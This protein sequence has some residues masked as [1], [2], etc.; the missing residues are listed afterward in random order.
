[1]TLS[2]SLTQWS[3]AKHKEAMRER[4]APL[5]T[6]L[7]DK[8]DKQDEKSQQWDDID[9]PILWWP[10]GKSGKSHWLH[11]H[12][13][14]AHLSVK[15]TQL[16][17]WKWKGQKAKGVHLG[18]SVDCTKLQRDSAGPIASWVLN[19]TKVSGHITYMLTSPILSSWNISAQLL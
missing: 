5:G 3:S 18:F 17:P 9:V 8:Q 19:S 12:A 15:C 1:M 14:V 7:Q 4:K 10:P 2:P 16:S 11:S 13:P 6:E